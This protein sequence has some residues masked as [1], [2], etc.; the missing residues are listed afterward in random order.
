MINALTKA[1]YWYILLAIIILMF[2]HY[3]RALRWQLFLAPIKNIHSGSLFSALLIGYAANTFLP[4]HLGEF[5]R[6]FVL[7]KKHNIMASTTFAS[8]VLE[9]II[10]IF[11][12]I[13]VMVL[14]ASIHPFPY[15]VAQS[16]L[17]MLGGSICLFAALISL[18]LFERKASILLHFLIKPL[19][20]RIGNK[21]VSLISNFL[22]GLIPLKSFW[23]YYYA[24]ILSVAIWSCYA[25]FYHFCLQAFKLEEIYN[26][27][28]YAGLVVLVFTTISIVVP[29]SPGYVGTYHYLCQLSLV[30]FGVSATEALS[31]ASVT[32]VVNILPA[33]FAGLI[34]ANYEGISIYRKA[35]EARDYHR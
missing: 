19:P 12:L 17:I 31:Y 5:L 10:D 30:M 11:S 21:I 20:E 2:G 29:T 4:A 18:K 7:G 24:A 1:N 3:L 26:L 14:V 35:S 9:R 22:S 23:N 25:F 34:M 13:A 33:T 16:G 27:A 15:W 6:A 28:W 32:H 8:I